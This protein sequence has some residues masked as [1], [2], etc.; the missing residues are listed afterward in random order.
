MTNNFVTARS[1]SSDGRLTP[2]QIGQWRNQGYTF[3]SGLLPEILV[4]ELR[5]AA[6]ARFPATGSEEAKKIADFGSTSQLDFS[7]QVSSLN[8]VTLHKCILGALVIC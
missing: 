4:K 2:E 7:S 1:C 8:E 6:R 5:Q 3:V